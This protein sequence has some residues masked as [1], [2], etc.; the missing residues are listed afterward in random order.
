MTIS[1]KK[2]VSRTSSKNSPK[3]KISIS[4][5][6]PT[7][8]P[9]PKSKRK[10]DFL[11]IISHDDPRLK[12]NKLCKRFSCQGG[13]YYNDE[14]EYW[15]ITPSDYFPNGDASFGTVT[16]NASDC[17]SFFFDEMT[18]K[19]HFSIIAKVDPTIP[20]LPKTAQRIPTKRRIGEILQ[21]WEDPRRYGAVIPLNIFV[22]N[23][24]ATAN[25]GIILSPDTLLVLDDAAGRLSS[26]FCQL[27]DIIELGNDIDSH[28]T[29]KQDFKIQF[30]LHFN[31]TI[32]SVG[33]N[34]LNK[35]RDNKRVGTNTTMAV[36]NLISRN[37]TPKQ[38]RKL[39]WG[40]K[41]PNTNVITWVLARLY[42]DFQIANS[43]TEFLPWNIEGQKANCNKFK[44]R[45]S[46][47]SIRAAFIDP[48]VRRVWINSKIHPDQAPKVLNESFKVFYELCP[49]IVNEV[50]QC[51]IKGTKSPSHAESGLGVKFVVCLA[52]KL[53]PFCKDKPEFFEELVKLTISEHY[54]QQ[55]NNSYLS[56]KVKKM[57]MDRFLRESIYFSGKQFNSGQVA[58]GGFLGELEPATD[59]AINTFKL[60]RKR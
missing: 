7:V 53:W 8:L 20:N 33:D 25:E 54:K 46:A 57:T 10:K 39:G 12:P 37:W 11:E 47:A 23:A 41:K 18:S 3:P 15:F 6:K 9:K 30:N 40:S 17:I 42:Q 26:I 28:V 21:D 34:F 16:Q 4:K 45:G 35:N 59:A 31:G 55:K 51:A 44:G 56:K 22:F 50:H 1:S 60:K 43:L 52:G 32:D 5:A 2:V 29:V 19:Q 48:K 36:E 38:V 14:K 24:T 13:V 49:E 58:A 27:D